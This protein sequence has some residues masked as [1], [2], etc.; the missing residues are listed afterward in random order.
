MAPL[1]R[2]P[3]VVEVEP[4]DHG[5]DIECGLHGIEL[6]AGSRNARAIGDDGAGHD[7]AQQLGA[8]RI[9]ERLQAAA[10]RIDEAIARGGVSQIAVDLVIQ[11]VVG[12]VGEDFVRRGA[13][14][15]DVR[16]QACSFF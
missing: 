12:D 11:S 8:G 7:G 9:F 14:I 16:G 2:E 1:G 15:A 6:K 3:G 10:E 13:F 5:A 4:A